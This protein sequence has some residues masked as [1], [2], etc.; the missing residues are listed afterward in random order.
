MAC[1]TGDRADEI[2][3]LDFLSMNLLTFT[4]GQQLVN[5]DASRA[6]HKSSETPFGAGNDRQHARTGK[7]GRCATWRLLFGVEN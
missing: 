3:P 1:G 5:H 4:S 6:D 2:T 7:P